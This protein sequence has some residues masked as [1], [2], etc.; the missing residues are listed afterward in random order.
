MQEKLPRITIITPSYN[1]GEFLEETILSVVNQNYSNL[2]YIIMDGGST[3]N[4]VDI[5]KKYEDKISYWV[6]EPDNG[7]ADAI[8]R[9]LEK[10]TGDIFAYI[11]SDDIF[12]PDS[13][14]VI[15][16]AFMSNP[17]AQW[18]V[19]KGYCI[20]EKGRFLNRKEYAPITFMNML[21]LEDCVMQPTAFWRKELYFSVGGIDTKYQFSFDY[22][23]FLKF[24]ERSKP[25]IVDHDVAAFRM[26]PLSKTNTIHDICLKE[27]YEIHRNY[28]LKGKNPFRYLTYWIFDKIYRRWYFLVKR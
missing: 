25:V 22:D 20:D 28:F 16:E 10:A 15:S 14:K 2:E 17:S 18:V 27:D 23:L 6:S 8:H 19:G 4:S 21:F 26:H 11:N 13:F 1:Q 3:D 24:V 12:L 5:I 9:G 7:Q